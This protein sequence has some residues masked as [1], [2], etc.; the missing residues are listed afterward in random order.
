M[1]P[2]AFQRSQK[3]EEGFIGAEEARPAEANVEETVREYRQSFEGLVSAN[4]AY[5][6]VF[7]S[8][9]KAREARMMGCKVKYIIVVI[10][11]LPQET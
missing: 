1:T 4:G 3:Y 6:S 10:A 2:E 7:G 11:L 9:V 8:Q 5:R